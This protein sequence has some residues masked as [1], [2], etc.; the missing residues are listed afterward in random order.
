MVENSSRWLMCHPIETC[1]VTGKKAHGRV[2]Q[3]CLCHAG[4]W[5]IG[6]KIQK[7]CVERTKNGSEYCASHS[8]HGR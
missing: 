4:M 7:A 3:R 6:D 1:M 5:G 2:T 8:V